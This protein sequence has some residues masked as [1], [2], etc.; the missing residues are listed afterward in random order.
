MR[1]GGLSKARRY[2]P[3]RKQAAADEANTKL[4]AGVKHVEINV[5]IK[6]CFG[7]VGD[8]HNFYS[9]IQ[10]YISAM[11]P[12][13]R[14]VRTHSQVVQS[15]VTS[16][17]T[18]TRVNKKDRNNKDMDM[19]GNPQLEAAFSSLGMKVRS[20]FSF[21]SLPRHPLLTRFSLSQRYSIP[22]VH[23]PC[24]SPSFSVLNISLGDT[25]SLCA[26]SFRLLSPWSCW[27]RK[28]ALTHDSP[29]SVFIPWGLV[30]VCACG[31]GR[32]SRGPP[33]GEREGGVSEER[34][35]GGH[36]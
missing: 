13:P 26:C 10:I 4:T 7:L 28:A 29:L 1:G 34:V 16:K 27:G 32:A 18:P 25:P 5:G 15:L 6:A 19:S 35:R 17:E 12:P 21:F 8:T 3:R 23:A 24:V 20:F 9:C 36:G 11:P 22:P 14:W 31:G 30:P 33:Q 2:S